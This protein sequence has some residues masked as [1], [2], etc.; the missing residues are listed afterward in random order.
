MSFQ[1]TRSIL[2]EVGRR[3]MVGCQEDLLTDIALDLVIRA[4]A[5][6]A[7]PSS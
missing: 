3:G 6:P 1:D 4:S 2:V 5:Q 7:L